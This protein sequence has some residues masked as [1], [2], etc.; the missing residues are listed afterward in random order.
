MNFTNAER[1]YVLCQLTQSNP[2]E[3]NP[4]PKIYIQVT[5]DGRR[6]LK[7]DDR[8]KERI[9]EYRIERRFG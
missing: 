6:A 1:V 8:K 7:K 2:I 9:I 3:F 4:Q 5:M